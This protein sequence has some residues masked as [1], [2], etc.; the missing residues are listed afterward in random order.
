MIDSFA[1]QDD[2]RG[3]RQESPYQLK[4]ALQ[5]HKGGVYQLLA[6][7]N[8]IAGLDLIFSCSND[9]TVRSWDRRTYLHIQVHS[10]VF[11]QVW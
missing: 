2:V 1:A 11:N 10:L 5:E 9:F 7:E 6:E 4:I 8:H 3:L